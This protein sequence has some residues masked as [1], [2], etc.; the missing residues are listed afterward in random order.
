MA[1]AKPMKETV[2]R[3]GRAA[4]APSLHSGSS[5]P[6]A[7][8]AWAGAPTVYKCFDR[9]LSVV[10]TDVPCVGEQMNIRAGDADPV[11]VAELQRER[12]AIAASAAQR[13]SDTP[14]RCARP[15]GR[16]GS[17]SISLR[18]EWKARRRVDYNVPYGYAYLPSTGCGARGHPWHTRRRGSTPSGPYRRSRE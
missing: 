15:G 17:T 16:G 6:R 14:A 3:V 18:K 4:A 5:R 2:R 12:Q 7:A 10:Y 9:N 13:I 11:A 1:N 8:H